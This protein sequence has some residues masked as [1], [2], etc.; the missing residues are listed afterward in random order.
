MKV[1]FIC[2]PG[3]AQFIP[4]I[5]K[6]VGMSVTTEVKEVY[7]NDG[8]EVLDAV[9]WAD[10]VWI[11]WAATHA[12]LMTQHASMLD[13]KK[14]I[15]RLHSGEAVNGY[16][17][18][19]NWSRVDSVVF[20]AKHIMDISLEKIKALT[21]EGKRQ[22]LPYF[23]PNH[24]DLDEWK[25]NDEE[26]WSPDIAWAPGLIRSLKGPMLMVQAMSGLVRIGKG[27]KLHVAG[28]WA[29]ERDR[30]Y[31]EHIIREL[32]LQDNIIFYGYV[33]GMQEWYKNMSYIVSFS[34]WE[35]NPV[36]ILEAMSTGLKPLIHNFLGSL[37]QYRKE[38]IWND[39][40]EFIGQLHQGV[41][42]PMLYRK[43]V[44]ENNDYNDRMKD[45]DQVFSDIMEM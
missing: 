25:F 44:Q 16:L 19:V 23:I 43:H 14:V 12:I 3:E 11:E 37:D 30:L 2:A 26:G 8:Q 6:H 4:G 15:V 5:A 17:L 21:E 18:D 13:G 42:D 29:D 31:V 39:V 9:R 28:N 33:K 1:A 38:W 27:W 10:V 36:S 20:V 34:S 24:I 40:P 45:I 35:G 22:P 41:G 7:S 32:N